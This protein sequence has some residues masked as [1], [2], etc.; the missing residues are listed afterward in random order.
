MSNEEDALALQVGGLSTSPPAQLGESKPGA[1]NSDTHV[2]NATTG[3]VK[4]RGD[5][6]CCCGAP[7]SQSAR[8]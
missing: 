1:A 4:C 8:S 6:G 7:H 2:V 3:P 5:N